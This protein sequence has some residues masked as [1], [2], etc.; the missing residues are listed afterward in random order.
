MKAKILTAAA[1]ALVLASCENGHD[2]DVSSS[3]APGTPCDFKKVGDRVHFGFDKSCLDPEAKKTVEA[4]AQWLKTYSNTKATV[5]GKCDERGTREY[6]IALGQRRAKNAA[7]A[8]KAN[9]VE[10]G[11]I[12]TMSFGKDRPEVPNAKTEAEHAQNR[13]AITEING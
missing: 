13:V 11:R 6:N 4:Q 1:A 8:L 7:T 3:Y 5:T 2:V 10:E 12:T 9:G